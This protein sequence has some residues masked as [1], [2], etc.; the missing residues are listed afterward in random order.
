M[1]IKFVRAKTDTMCVLLGVMASSPFAFFSGGGGERASY[2][3]SWVGLFVSGFNGIPQ[4]LNCQD[5][6]AALQRIARD[7]RLFYG[8]L[9]QVS[10]AGSQGIEDA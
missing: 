2:D 3:V 5:C 4:L 9:R 8:T 6:H 10:R 7:L 1:L